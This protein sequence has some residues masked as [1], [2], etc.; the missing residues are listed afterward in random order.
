MKTPLPIS[1]VS[2]C[3]NPSATPD[4]K[5]G[6]ASARGSLPDRFAHQRIDISI[7]S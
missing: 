6:A 4:L 3:L 2:G 1:K 5:A 7:T